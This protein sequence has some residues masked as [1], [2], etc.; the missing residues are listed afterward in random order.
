MKFLN[1]GSINSND[2]GLEEEGWA[3]RRPKKK[4]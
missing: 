3:R 1:P 2:A 4:K